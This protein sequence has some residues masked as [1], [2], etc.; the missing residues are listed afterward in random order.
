MKNLLLS[1]LLMFGCTSVVTAKETGRF[2][3]ESRQGVSIISIFD[4]KCTD[5][6]VLAKAEGI[7][8]PKEY[9]DQLMVIKAD[10]AGDKD[11]GC[12]V[13]VGG[14]LFVVSPKYVGATNIDESDFKNP[15]EVTAPGTKRM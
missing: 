4:D 6:A 15:Q 1:L 14:T 8:M 10:F 7:G 11:E 12:Y 3:Q 2:Q 9:M 13:F 5:K